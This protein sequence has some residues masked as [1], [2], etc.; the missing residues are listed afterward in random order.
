VPRKRA[1]LARAQSPVGNSQKHGLNKLEEN[2]H[3]RSYS[4]EPNFATAIA[5]EMQGLC[6]VHTCGVRVSRRIIAVGFLRHVIGEFPHVSEERTA[7]VFRLTDSV[8]CGC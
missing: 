7:D 8:S 3:W 6:A 5:G 4:T 2:T 1:S